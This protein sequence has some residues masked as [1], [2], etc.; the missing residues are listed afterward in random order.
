M[1]TGA[2]VWSRAVRIPAEVQPSHYI[3]NVITVDYDYSNNYLDLT[4]SRDPFFRHDKPVGSANKGVDLLCI[5]KR[6]WF[7]EEG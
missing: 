2:E 4:Y 1:R 5:V 7:T 3:P 6:A